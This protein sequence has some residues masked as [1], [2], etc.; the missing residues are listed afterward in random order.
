MALLP[1]NL[2]WDT[3]F[4]DGEGAAYAFLAAY[5]RQRRK[6]IYLFLLFCMVFACAFALYHIPVGAVLYPALVCAVLGLIVLLL[7]CRSAYRKHRALT[8]V[9]AARKPRKRER[10]HHRRAK[11]ALNPCTARTQ[12]SF[13]SSQETV[14]YTSVVH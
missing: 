3:L 8:A 6:V 9:S 11:R 7:D 2:V 1:L 5:F 12:R 10:R 13:N 4:R 14:L